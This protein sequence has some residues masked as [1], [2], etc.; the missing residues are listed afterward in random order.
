MGNFLTPDDLGVS[1]KGFFGQKPKVTLP[2]PVWTN[3]GNIS[4]SEPILAIAAGGG[5]V[6]A[7][8]D[9]GETFRSLDGG[10]TWSAS[11][12]NVGAGNGTLYSNMGFDSGTWLYGGDGNFLPISTNNGTSWGT[13]TN[14]LG[15]GNNGYVAT[16]GAGN[17]A[18]W[19]DAVQST[20]NIFGISVDNG[21]TFSQ[22]ADGARHAVG[23]PIWDPTSA[24][25]AV[26][27]RQNV[28]GQYELSTHTNTGGS[29][30]STS[31]SSHLWLL[32]HSDG[33]YLAGVIDSPS[34]RSASTLAGLVTATDI[35]LASVGLTSGIIA[36]LAGGGRYF[37]FDAAGHAAY[38]A[39]GSV[40]VSSSLPL[41]SE[42]LSESVG[43]VAYD[44]T[45]STWIV[46]GDRGSIL[47]LS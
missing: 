23:P 5:I 36:L 38:S 20:P 37:A 19:C 9:I 16:D 26:C 41:V 18:S 42:G 1:G 40:W 34:V 39:N 13:T 17:W 25:F 3:R 29:L 33:V 15:S 28:S 43:A 6:L 44:P 7:V 27:T 35:S 22:I 46:G 4:G 2:A 21:V 14:P 12:S 47:T 10:V 45:H 31:V 8:D 24:L 11:I 30:T 32:A